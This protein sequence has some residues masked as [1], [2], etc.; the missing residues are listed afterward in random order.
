MNTQFK[1][2][3]NLVFQLESGFGVLRVL[4]VEEIEGDTIWHL[5][6]YEDLYPD[7]E[8]AEI[9]LATSTRMLLRTPHLAVTNY[10]FEKTA[11]SKLDNQPVS[12]EELAAYRLW[13]ETGGDAS[14]RS[15]VMMLGFR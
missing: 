3:D 15:V 12:D 10:A 14:N 4:V 7:V 1:P 5:S 13:K 2:G 8:T 9:A 11:A 6:V